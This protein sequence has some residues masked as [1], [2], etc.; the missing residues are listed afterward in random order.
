MTRWAHQSAGSNRAP[1]YVT[2]AP[3]YEAAAG[4]RAS[5]GGVEDL[6]SAA[7]SQR[8]MGS[9]AGGARREIISGTCRAIH[10]ASRALGGS[11]PISQ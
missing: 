4:Q 1:A 8:S 3:R 10:V 11:L 9:P 2:N 6:A 7:K 5:C